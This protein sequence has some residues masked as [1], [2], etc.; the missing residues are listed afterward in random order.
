MSLSFAA[1]DSHIHLPPPPS[2]E[3]VIENRVELIE[4]E[5]QNEMQ[6][7]S[8][9]DDG[10]EGAVVAAL[11]LACKEAGYDETHDK[12][13]ELVAALERVQQEERFPQ[14]IM[15]IVEEKTK[16][17]EGRATK[18][19]RP[20]VQIVLDGMREAVQVEEERRA[21]V[22]RQQE[23]ERR[24][25]EQGRI[26]EARRQEEARLV[27]AREEEAQQERLRCSGLCPAGYA[28]HRCGAGWRCNG[29]SHY[30]S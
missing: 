19:L 24:M 6:E 21:E 5:L 4:V 3:L 7:S 15:T 29:G 17:T 11:L 2:V 13:Q 16:L 26:E 10:D 28:W 20:Q 23:E 25:I 14:D 9:F 18:L 22:L 12:R 27:R 1:F 30:C 8:E